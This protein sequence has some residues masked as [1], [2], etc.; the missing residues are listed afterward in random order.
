M[1]T[2]KL[3]ELYQESKGYNAINDVL[4][5]AEL[6]RLKENDMSLED[7]AETVDNLVVMLDANDKFEA[8]RDEYYQRH[9]FNVGYSI[10]LGGALLGVVL[11]EVGPKIIKLFKKK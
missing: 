9:N 4:I 5:K 2:K 10:G 11:S 1:K 3:K 6:R 7:R 8:V